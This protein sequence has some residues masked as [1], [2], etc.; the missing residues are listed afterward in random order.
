MQ[1]KLKGMLSLALASILAALVFFHLFGSYRFTFEGIELSVSTTLSPRGVTQI[2]I[3]PLGLVRA[4]T[5]HTPVKL[6]IRVENI[7]LEEVQSAL[8]NKYNKEELSEKLATTLQREVYGFV[9]KI[10]F[11][12]GLAGLFAALIIRPPNSSAYL[13]SVLI[14]ASFTGLLLFATYQDY[15]PQEFSHPEYEGALKAAPWMIAIAEDTLAKIDTLSNKLQLVAENFNLL[16][17][18][19]DNL[20]P[21]QTSEGN[22]KVL[23]VSDI[24]NNPAALQFIGKMAELFEVNFIIDTGDISDFGTPLEGILLDKIS[25]LNI[26]YFFVAGNHDSPTIINKMRQL[27]KNVIIAEEPVQIA[28]LNI[29]GFPD[30]ASQTNQIQSLSSEL[31]AEYVQKYIEKLN[32]YTKDDNSLPIDIIAVHSPYIAEPLAG[33]APVL[34]FGHNHQYNVKEINGSVLVNAGTSGASGLGTLQEKTQ[35]PYSLMLLHFY[36]EGDKNRLLAVDAIQIDSLTTEFSMQRHLFTD[37]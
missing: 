32:N 14:A 31:E 12:A 21:V 28:G 36:R 11:I 34:V 20:E 23:H 8:E 30:P 24:H 10:I 7:D 35:R 29:I 18:Q 15:K 27:K 6:N 37:K 22:I 2:E 16:Y 1:L 26:P 4:S 3:P 5:H 25:D 13:K 9:T 19:I 33:Y 17:N